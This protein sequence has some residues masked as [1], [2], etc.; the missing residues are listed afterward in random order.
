MGSRA[1]EDGGYSSVEAQ[2]LGFIKI[3]VKEA[4]KSPFLTG[5]LVAGRFRL[6]Q[7]GA[8]GCQGHDRLL[9]R[10]R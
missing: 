7:F 3:L 1:M 8:G 5:S 2:D 6:N 4:K 10:A 9:C